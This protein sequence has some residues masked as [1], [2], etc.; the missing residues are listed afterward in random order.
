MAVP[1]GCLQLTSCPQS[2]W[3]MTLSWEPS[4]ISRGHVPSQG[5]LRG[6]ATGNHEGTWQ[7]TSHL[8][9]EGQKMG[10]SL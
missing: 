7:G 9:L 5:G 6:G 1:C 8:Q 3:L 4:L 10:C 2:L